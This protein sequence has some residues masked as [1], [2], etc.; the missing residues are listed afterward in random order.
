[1][2]LA[3]AAAGAAYTK[4]YP[5]IIAEQAGLAY[6]LIGI[7]VVVVGMLVWEGLVYIHNRK[8][9]KV[10]L[11]IAA[12]LVIAAL[13]AGGIVL[14]NQNS[15]LQADAIVEELAGLTDFSNNSYTSRADFIR[16]GLDIVK[17]HPV[18]GA[19]AGGWNALYHHYQDYLIFTTEAHNHFIQVWVEAGTIG[20]LAFLAIW[21]LFFRTAY[22]TYRRAKKDGHT[23]QQILIGGTV[24]AATALGIHAAIDFD[25]SLAAITLVLWILFA[26]ISAVSGFTVEEKQPLLKWASLPS[27]VNLGVAGLCALVLIICGIS[28][29]SAYNHATT[30]S[31]AIQ[32]VSS[33]K[34]AE[35][36]NELFQTALRHYEKATQL[37]SLNAEYQADLAYV[38]ALTYRSLKESGH[39]LADQVYQQTVSA[40][41]AAERLKPYD[42]KLRSSL[43]STA[44]MLG[45]FTLM[46]Q[47]AEGSLL[48][49]PNDINSYEVLVKVLAAGL[50]YY[51]QNGDEEQTAQLAQKMADLQL[52]LEEQKAEI[53]PDR[54]WYGSPLH[55]S[56][57][58]QYNIAR[59]H[60]L[61]GNYQES[62][63]IFEPYTTNLLKLEFADTE[64]N[65]TSLE[66]ENWV[67]STVKDEE[68]VN[69]TCLKAVAKH[70]QKGWPNVVDLAS[71]IPVQSG[72]EYVLEVRY[73]IHQ[74][75]PGS[76]AD[77][78]NSAGIWSWISGEKESK[79]TSFGFHSGS[80]DTPQTSWN[81]AQQ[82]L[83]V[84]EGHQWRSLYIGTGSVGAS[85]TFF[86]DY[87]KFYPLLN[88]NTPQP[89]LDQFT[90]YAASLY[91]TGAT[92]EADNIG[93]QLKTLNTQAYSTYE[94][95]IKQEPL[96]TQINVI[97]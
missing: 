53:N 80:V 19:G 23:Q 54:T 47:Q 11:A 70:D 55:L 5:A 1:M 32:S 52:T 16:W 89:V 13:G 64:F 17:D 56:A 66:N 88:Q 77:T 58:A 34:P 75:T 85:T 40:I 90:W 83:V 81:I 51:Q 6:L 36:Q 21:I 44:N 43:F 31:A 92:A 7:L 35:E 59:S 79:N 3:A 46:L 94:R 22:Q 38:Y 78:T 48:P 37:N 86:I 26:L 30:A 27:I 97:N 2:A 67:L 42:T 28:Y 82:K 72:V 61:L 12:I 87:V 45:D 41:E 73:R 74:F 65:N 57:E 20:L 84:D 4:F 91:K 33:D 49:N 96:K 93:Q 9:Y 24:T 10:T 29:Y 71:K 18:N 14:G 60:Y 68:A 62:L 39:Q 69:G 15:P 95:L 50:D 25:L 63:V 76:K 8:G